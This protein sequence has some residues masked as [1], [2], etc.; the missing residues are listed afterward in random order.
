MNIIEKRLA[1]LANL[2]SVTPGDQIKLTPDWKLISGQSSQSVLKAFRSQGYKKVTNPAK[3]FFSVTGTEDENILKFCKEKGIKLIDCEPE[4][5]FRKEGVKQNGIV[6][7]GID[8]HIK[9]MGGNGAIPIV[10]SPAS[11]ADC[12]A[13]S[14]FSM[15]IPDTI[16]IEINGPVYE[17]YTGETL[18]SYLLDSFNDSLIGNAVILGGVVLEQLNNQ[19]RKNLSYFFQLSGAAVGIISAEG[20]LGQVESVIKMKLQLGK[21]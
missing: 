8:Q 13:T 21:N 12:L 4:D 16:Y 19:D 14:S 15:V 2:P 3:T 9:C 7:A 18:C 11:M 6:L 10:I 5:Y 20:P 1:E 17:Q